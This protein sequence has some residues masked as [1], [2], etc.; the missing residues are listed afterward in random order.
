[1]AEPVHRDAFGIL[2]A[3]AVSPERMQWADLRPST[4]EPVHILLFVGPKSLQA[5][6]PQGNAVAL[7]TDM[8]GNLVPDGQ[9]TFQRDGFTPMDAT[10]HDGLAHLRFAAPTRAGTYDIHATIDGQQSA[11]AQLRVTAALSSISP[12]LVPADGPLRPEKLTTFASRDLRDRYGNPVENGTAATLML[13]HND[14][15]LSHVVAPV[16]AGRV[17]VP[18]LPRDVDAGGTLAL[19]VGAQDTAASVQFAPLAADVPVAAQLWTP[20]AGLLALRVGPLTTDAGYLLPDGAPIT[21]QA[22]A[23]QGATDTR[24]GWV[25]DGHF[26]TLLSLRPATQPVRL[27]IETALGIAELHV[28]TGPAPADL[29]GAP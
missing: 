3:S 26:Q 14:G 12:I 21:V 24:T 4:N 11:R 29:P 17:Q 8:W 1:M 6:G 27:T 10:L 9:V 18:F 25:R 15:T 20:T 16:V 5:G 23:S 2:P 28:E 13:Q 19:S 7:V 22:T